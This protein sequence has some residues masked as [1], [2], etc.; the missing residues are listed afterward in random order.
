MRPS[1]YLSFL[2][3]VLACAS[4]IEH[5]AGT[6]NSIRRELSRAIP[7]QQNQTEKIDSSTPFQ[8]QEDSSQGDAAQADS[9]EQ[10]GQQTNATESNTGIDDQQTNAT[11]TNT[12]N[13]NQHIV[14]QESIPTVNKQ[15]ASTEDGEAELSEQLFNTENSTLTADN[16]TLPS[17]N[18]TFAANASSVDTGTSDEFSQRFEGQDDQQATEPNISKQPL[19]TDGSAQMND[20]SQGGQHGQGEPSHSSEGQDSQQAAQPEGSSGQPSSVDSSTQ[21]DDSPQGD[22]HAQQSQGQDNQ[23]AAQSKAGPEQSPSIDSST[24]T[25]GFPQGNQDTQGGIPQSPEGK[26]IQQASGPKEVPNQAATDDSPQQ[27]EKNTE[28]TVVGAKALSAQRRPQQASQSSIQKSGTN[29]TKPN[30]AQQF[31]QLDNATQATQGKAPQTL[32]ASSGGPN[33]ILRASFTANAKCGTSISCNAGKGNTFSGV[34]GIGATAV[35]HILFGGPPGVWDGSK[36]YT[37]VDG[38]GA[39]CGSCWTLTPGFNYHEGNGKKLGQTVV[40][41]INDACTDPGYCDQEAGADPRNTGPLDGM[42]PSGKYNAQVHF[43][44]CQATGVAQAFFG[45]VESGVAIG[46]A[47]FNPGCIGLEDMEFGLTKVKKLVMPFASGEGGG[48]VGGNGAG[49]AKGVFR[50]GTNSNSTL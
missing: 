47:Q 14:Q 3:C 21:L 35:N 24:Q 20:F 16:S 44:L 49:G 11:N 38:K 43:D 23:K 30:L 42:G 27:A 5:G 2:F 17:D 31:E 37:N 6:P 1:I 19:S 25:D 41:M 36:G 29:P 15:A 7:Q 32:K 22:Q 26:T 45:E 46:A 48:V 9:A 12:G 10:V 28:T 34:N 4:P 33:P 50:S 40:V 13:A 39:S 18:S 8:G